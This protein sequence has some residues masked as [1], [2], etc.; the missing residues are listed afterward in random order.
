MG[1]KTR[2]ELFAEAVRLNEEVQKEKDEKRKGG[3]SN[4]EDREK[5]EWTGLESK[6]EMV[7]RII[8]NPIIFRELSTDPKVVFRSDKIVTDKGDTAIQVNW[9]S[10]KTEKG[11]ELDE[12]WILFKLHKTI[13]EKKFIKYSDGH[14]NDKGYDGEYKFVNE[15]KACFKRVQENSKKDDK[16]PCKFYPRERVL[17]NVIDRQDSWC[18][19]NNHTKLLSSK[20]GKGKADDNGNPILYPDCG[21]PALLYS[22]IMQ[23]VCLYRKNWDLDIVIRKNSENI[24]DAY[25]VR[26]IRED[27]IDPATKA[28][29]NDEPLID[30]E[31]NYIL[32]DLDKL[33]VNCSYLKLEKNLIGLFRMTDLE[34]N[35]NFE[36]E[37]KALVAKEKTENDAKK[38]LE[39]KEEEPVKTEVKVEVKKEEPVKTRQKAPE[40]VKTE[41][42]IEDLCK[43]NFPNFD[44]LSDKEK[45]NLVDSIKTFG[46][47][48]PAYINVQDALPCSKE[49]CT[50][51]DSNIQ[52]LFPSSVFTCPVCGTVDESA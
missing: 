38:P 42:S 1:N 43:L 28:L 4:W 26:D 17:M 23:S 25:N 50:Y 20:V 47:K 31:M 10:K 12:D 41:K 46:N 5:I 6:K 19:D 9:P 3:N 2:E 21:I 45:K 52:T 27:K 32:Y 35:T 29:G 48:V 7:Y 14:K 40:E 51:V 39:T 44:K 8:G 49:G 16:Y 33:F 13:M 22:K 37:L 30:L 18:K 11:Y 36:I 24:S 34:L 15:G